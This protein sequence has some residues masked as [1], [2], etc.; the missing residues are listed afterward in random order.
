MLT[1]VLVVSAGATVPAAQAV[2]A[3][4]GTASTAPAVH[5]VAQDD[6]TSETGDPSGSEESPSGEPEL[7][8]QTEAEAERNKDKIVVGVIA[9]ILLGI[10]AWGRY[11]RAKN[12]KGG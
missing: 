1:V 9:A 5:V 12:A 11:I 6:T 4:S 7:D 10:V 8:P 3:A 2:P